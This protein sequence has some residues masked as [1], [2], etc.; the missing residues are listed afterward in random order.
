MSSKSAISNRTSSKWSVSVLP[1]TLLVLLS[2]LSFFVAYKVSEQER[3]ERS[4][5]FRT[6]S[7][8]TAQL[9]QEKIN[10]FPQLLKSTRGM[11]INQSYSPSGDNWT[12]FFNSLNL[13]YREL[14]IIGITFTEY[15]DKRTRDLFLHNKRALYGPQFDIFPQTDRDESFVVM[16]ASPANI[17]DK[18]RGYDIA[19]EV[20][21]YDAAQYSKNS[22]QIA[23]TDPIS[24]LP[25]DQYS[26]D[27]LM[28]A[29]V[30]A[31]T[32][33]P[34][35]GLFLDSDIA[36]SGWVTIGFSLS[37]LIDQ[38]IAN[39]GEPLRIQVRDPRSPGGIVNF[40]SQPGDISPLQVEF[41]QS[42]T[43]DIS[44]EPI[45]LIIMPSA[46]EAA[47]LII[48]RYNYEV[49]SISLLTSLLA[50]ISL[51][52]VLNARRRALSLAERMVERSRETNVRYQALFEQSPEAVIIHIQRG[53]VLCNES[54]VRLMGASSTSDLIGR[55]ILDLVHPDSRTLVEQRLESI[56]T[57][58]HLKP[59][60]QRIMRLD[61]STFL[62]EVSSSQITYDS[63]PGI[64]VMFRDITAAKES[65]NQAR[66]A[67]R[68][69]EHT[70]ESIM[71]TDIH[72]K[73]VMTNP[74]F[75]ELTGYKREEILSQTPSRLSSGHHDSAFFGHMWQHLIS[76]GN[77]VGEIVNRRKNGEIYIQQTNISAVYDKYGDISHFVCLMGDITEQKKAMDSIRFQ[78]MHDNLTRLANRPHFEARAEEALRRAQQ[79]GDL[80]AVMFIDLDGFKQINDTW[81]HAVGDKLLITV[82]ERLNDL[83]QPTDTLARI[84][85]RRVPDYGGGTDP[86]S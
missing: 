64:Q 86:Q 28:L 19:S 15:V 76:T 40:D 13:D 82:A 75:T 6:T 52:L 12:H 33:Q 35:S 18:I 25:T 5:Q 68:V 10:H 47:A 67:Q 36:F 43:L 45:E 69:L 8:Q 4:S 34:D 70:R 72:G 55:D 66:I 77:W 38:S 81:G 16:Q 9:I 74:S 20:R 78:A 44:D 54:A 23:I 32:E 42:H 30:Y 49:L 50:A 83:L 24:L 53:I 51:R 14:G 73:I 26:L 41:Q 37:M 65:L 39:L 85:R 27:Y 84:W 62:A 57:R 2:T 3:N 31:N 17:A 21:R 80:L 63:Q 29:P 1:V 79:T 11:V 7:T 61:G 58:S 71:V 60:E 22:G 46:V 59:V 48:P 56:S